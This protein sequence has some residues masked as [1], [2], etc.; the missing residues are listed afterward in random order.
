MAALPP[1]HGYEMDPAKAG[2]QDVKQNQQNVLLVTQSFL[3][4]IMS[5]IPAVPSYGSLTLSQAV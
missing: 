5:S 4:I 2:E 1:G 3:E